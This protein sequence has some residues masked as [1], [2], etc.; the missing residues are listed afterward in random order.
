LEEL[1]FLTNTFLPFLPPLEETLS[2]FP[3]T[4]LEEETL[5]RGAKGGGP[6]ALN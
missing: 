4:F 1:F 2:T 6:V 3:Q 5:D